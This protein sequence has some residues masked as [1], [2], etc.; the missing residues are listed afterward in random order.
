VLALPVDGV[1]E[2]FIDADDI[3]D[4]ATAA[5]AE[6]EHTG[7]VY[8]LTGP[9]LLTFAEAVQEIAEASGRELRFQSM[10]MDEYAT[11]LAQYGVPAET[12]SLLTYL[13]SEV[14]DGRN[15][16]LSDDVQRALGRQPQDFRDYARHTAAT[17]VWDG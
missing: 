13:F 15:A 8:E 17:G 4:I 6:P 1:Q 12:V 10:P 16:S 7:Q 9:R 14:L 2:P 11:L 3:A 5:L